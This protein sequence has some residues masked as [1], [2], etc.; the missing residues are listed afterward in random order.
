MTRRT[1]SLA[2]VKKAK[3]IKDTWMV[4]WRS[5]L[6]AILIQKDRQYFHIIKVATA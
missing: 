4:S 1:S 2:T 5:E 3:G 6:T